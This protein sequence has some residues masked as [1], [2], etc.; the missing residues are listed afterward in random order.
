MF[1]VGGERE[2][3]LE[4]TFDNRAGSGGICFRVS[5]AIAGRGFGWHRYRI[6][7]GL[8]VRVSLSVLRTVGLGWAGFLLVSGPSCLFFAPLSSA[9]FSV[10]RTD[11]E[12]LL[13]WRVEYPASL[14][15][16]CR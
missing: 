9:V 4:K 8:S 7:G 6:P 15:F 16:R 2:N 1:N 10:T 11:R 3:E 5:I 13:S 12:F 14:F